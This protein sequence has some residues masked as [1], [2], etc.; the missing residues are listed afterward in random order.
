MFT[1]ADYAVGTAAALKLIRHE[2]DV[3][4]M[5]RL[6]MFIPKSMIP[7]EKEPEAAAMITKCVLDAVAA[8]HPE[9]ATAYPQP[10]PLPQPN[11]PKAG[12]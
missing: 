8:A 9:V 4:L 11:P 3:E 5:P 12:G 10:N 2:V 7:V 6:P 1:P